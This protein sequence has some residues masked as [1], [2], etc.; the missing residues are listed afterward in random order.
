MLQN[1]LSGWIAM[2]WF[3]TEWKTGW[4]LHVFVKPSSEPARSL[5]LS[6]LWVVAGVTRGWSQV[7]GWEEGEYQIWSLEP[8]KKIWKLRLSINYKTATFNTAKGNSPLSVVPT[9]CP[10]ACRVL[11]RPSFC[12]SDDHLFSGCS[13]G[14]T[15]W[16]TPGVRP[17]RDTA[18]LPVPVRGPNS[19]SSW[20]DLQSRLSTSLRLG[21]GQDAL[22]RKS[23]LT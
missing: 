21:D 1:L 2:S 7:P 22:I 8:C 23:A 12:P 5:W 17:N 15:G 6:W 18:L 10:E 16:Q 4:F 9:R 11:P 20:R 3:C 19:N 14:S 13:A